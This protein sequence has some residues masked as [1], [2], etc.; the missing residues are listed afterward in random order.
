[1]RILMVSDVYFP[2]INGVSTAIMIL[3]R[4]LARAGHEVTLV[5]P[6]YGACH[7]PGDGPGPLYRVRSRS[8]WRD[9]EDR[10]MSWRALMDLAPELAR[11]GFDLV[12]VHTPFLA[13]YAGLAYARRLGVPVVETY[14]TLFEEYLFHYV[15]LAPHGLMRGLTRALARLQC[16]QVDGLV[17]PSH[18]MLQRLVEYGVTTRA[19]VIPTGL[20][21]EDFAGGDGARF[22]AWLDIPPTR[23]VLLYVGRVAHEKNIGFLLE[24]MARLTQRLPEALLVIA[25]EGPA[26]EHLRRQAETL[27]VAAQVRFVGYLDRQTALLDCYRAADVFV[28]ASRTETQGLVLLEAMALGVPVVGLAVMGTAEVLRD[29]EGALIAQDDVTDFADKVE[30]LLKDHAARHELAVRARAY[31]QTWSAP[32]MTA[33]L[34][35]FY[36][37]TLEA[38]AAGGLSRT[39]SA[40]AAA[41]RAESRS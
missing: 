4:E 36:A 3:R 33:R 28:F 19:A 17:V 23:P 32:E 13:H 25:G 26:Q 21:L 41:A 29:G 12:H 1:M 11:R 40:A 20:D 22:R 37:E 16:A 38:R 6:D 15:P 14:H 30:R 2:R 39:G 35:S 5:A 10:R 24:V 18:P 34:I 7:V 31:A 27:G 9:P 8:V